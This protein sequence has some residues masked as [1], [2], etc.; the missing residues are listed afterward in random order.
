MKSK[1]ISKYASQLIIMSSIIIFFLPVLSQDNSLISR[2]TV[3]GVPTKQL[4]PEVEKYRSL[5]HSKDLQA[6]S[7][8]ALALRKWMIAN[9]PFRPIY[10]FTGPESWIND[11]NGPI[12]YNDK[13]HLFYQYNPIVDSKKSKTCWGHAVSKDLVHWVDW[14]VALWPDTPQDSAGVYS[15]NTFIDDNGDLCALYTGNVRGHDETYGILARSADEFLT[16]TKEVVMDDNQRPNASV[17]CALGWLP[18][19]GREN[20]VS[21]DRRL[22]RK[23][24]SCLVVEIIRSPEVDIA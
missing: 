10:H 14:P 9:D 17:S 8:A 4:A 12:Y 20:L 23:P 6:Y 24:G 22:Y 7:S 21:A 5:L 15:G 16:S 11:P 13:Y 18:L 19:E 3:S 1:N 2:D